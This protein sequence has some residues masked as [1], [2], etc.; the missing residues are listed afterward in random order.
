[1]IYG[2]ILMA[3]GFVGWVL[4]R[5]IIKKDLHQYREE[6][7]LWLFFLAAWAAIYWFISR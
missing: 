4:Y 7:Q 6:T 1:M 3:I 2:G 5:W